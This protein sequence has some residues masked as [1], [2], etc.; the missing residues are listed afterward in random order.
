MLNRVPRTLH[1][2]GVDDATYETLHA[3]AS[4]AGLPL[5]QYLRI[6]LDRLAS[7]PTWE[8]LLAEADDR[9]AG[10]AGAG[11]GAIVPAPDEGRAEHGVYPRS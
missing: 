10:G 8:E 1:I 9:R 7:T 11:R 3:R 6:E 5:T 4:A 2:R